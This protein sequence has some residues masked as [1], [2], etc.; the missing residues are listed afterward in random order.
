MIMKSTCVM[1][2]NRSNIPWFLLHKCSDLHTN[3]MIILLELIEKLYLCH[4]QYFF[5]WVSYSFH[6]TLHRITSLAFVETRA[7][8]NQYLFAVSLTLYLIVAL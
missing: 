1:K 4:F 6:D 3:S 7:C 5:S 8:G 2:N